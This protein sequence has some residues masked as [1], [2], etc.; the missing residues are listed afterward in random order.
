MKM[1]KHG[2]EERNGGWKMKSLLTIFVLLPLATAAY[3]TDPCAGH[4]YGPDP[5]TN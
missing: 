3:A 4:G 5:P 2:Q 1:M